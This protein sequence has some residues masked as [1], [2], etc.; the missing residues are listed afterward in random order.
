MISLSVLIASTMILSIIESAPFLDILYETASALATVGLS[1]GM[2]STLTE[3]GKI[4][5]ILTMYLGRIGPMTMALSFNTK[6]PKMNAKH[7][8]SEKVIVG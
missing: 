1:R 6:K 5:L 8:P 3:A 7:L 2:T 4:A